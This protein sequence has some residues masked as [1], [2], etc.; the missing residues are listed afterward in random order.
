MAERGSWRWD[1]DRHELVRTA[2]AAELEQRRAA[3]DE[4]DARVLHAAR[5]DYRRDIRRGA[6]GP[7]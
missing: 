2:D 7:R 5:E 6:S 1:S 4:A 3:R